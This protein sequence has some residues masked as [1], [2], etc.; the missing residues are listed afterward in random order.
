MGEFNQKITEKLHRS[1]FDNREN[2][3]IT[4]TI[5]SAF[6][7]YAFICWD[8]FPKIAECFNI[9]NNCKQ[10]TRQNNRPYTGVLSFQKNLPHKNKSPKTEIA[11][12]I[13][14]N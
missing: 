11:F 5:S 10:P 4:F 14:T 12:S 13:V 3:T 8:V 7:F 9:T 2:S 1:A 6:G